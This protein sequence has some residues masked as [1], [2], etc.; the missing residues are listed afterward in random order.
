[1]NLGLVIILIV[2]FGYMSNSINWRYLN[3]KV[4]QYLYYIGAFVHESSHA[5]LCLLTGAKIYEFKV[6]S[7]Q[8]HVTHTKSKI[9]LVGGFL[10]SSAPIFGGLFFLYIINHFALNDRFSVSHFSDDWLST[11]LEPI[12]LI[13][14][15][16]FEW[17]SLVMILLLL[18]VGAMIGPSMQDIKNIWPMIILSFFVPSS[19][20][21]NFCLIA[22]SLILLNIIIQ[23]TLILILKIIEKV[24]NRT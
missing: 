3:F 13:S 24:K 11:L 7:S 15:M 17:Q 1:M 16:K 8:P 23:L 5:I 4:T 14:Q 18:N 10:I 20:L 12:R 22:L 6:F 9:P 19:F 2:V 21:I